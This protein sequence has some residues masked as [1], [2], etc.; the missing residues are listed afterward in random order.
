MKKSLLYAS[1][2]LCIT[3]LTIAD[4]A[5]AKG[6][7]G[8]KC[9]DADIVLSKQYPNF[10]LNHECHG[11][12]SNSGDC[13]PDNSNLVDDGAGLVIAGSNKNNII[14]GSSGN[15]TICGGNGN[16]EIYGEEGDDTIYGDNGKDS[17]YGGPGDDELHGGNGKD[18]LSGY[19]DDHENAT[20]AGLYTDEDDLY[21]ENS[22]DH[23]SGGPGDDVLSGGNGKDSMDGGYGADDVSGDKGKDDCTDNDDDLAINECTETELED[24]PKHR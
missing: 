20:D 10:D 6:K 21:G 13:D 2:C 7:P 16:D 9:P 8:S 4:V 18:H 17:L 22:N 12:Y 1:I 24:G 11:A 15:D 14:H 23:L 3:G 5:S 19:D